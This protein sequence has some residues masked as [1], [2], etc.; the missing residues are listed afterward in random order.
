MTEISPAYDRDDTDKPRITKSRS[1][2]NLAR[3]CGGDQDGECQDCIFDCLDTGKHI[4]RH[5]RIFL[6]CIIKKRPVEPASSV[7]K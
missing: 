3:V 2:I 4:S 7:Q 1:R 5:T 6:T